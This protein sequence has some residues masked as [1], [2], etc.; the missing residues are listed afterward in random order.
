MM[1]MIHTQDLE[2]VVALALT[3]AYVRGEKPISLMIVSDRPESGKTEIVNRFYGN[4]GIA[5][6]SDVTAYGFWRD[7]SKD[8]I[9]GKLKH[10][11]IPELLAPISRG[12]E[13]VGSFIATLQMLVEEGLTEIHTGFLRP[14]KLDSPVTVGVIACLPRSAFN[15]HKMDWSISGFLS[16]FLVVT[17][18]YDDASVDLIFQS[19]VEREYLIYSRINLRLDSNSSVAIDIPQAVASECRTMAETITAQARKDGKCYGFRELKSLLRMVASNVMLDRCLNSTDR[20]EANLADFAEISRLGY[21][22]NEQFNAVKGGDS[23]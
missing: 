12:A 15:Q 3:S 7:F 8:L 22:I 20:T 6:L 17:Y 2:K 14:I 5:I 11:I 10:I 21:L 4:T 23:E 19:I 18:K 1:T 9:S 13:T 16:R